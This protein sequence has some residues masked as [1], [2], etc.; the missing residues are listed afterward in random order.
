MNKKTRFVLSLFVLIGALL[1]LAFLTPG[2]IQREAYMGAEYCG[3]CHL[4]E[5]KAWSNSSH[6]KAFV[7]LPAD[8]K[9]ERACLSC[10]AMGTFEKHD[11]IFAG[12]QCESCHGPGLYY[13]VPHSK[14][15]AV[16]SKLLFMNKAESSCI[17][18]HLQNNKIINNHTKFNHA[19]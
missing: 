17:T 18:C 2:P 10:H 8:K 11:P 1:S 19:Q 12:V 13:A 15:D 6:S 4:E 3:S 7:H 14:K 5:Y 16:L 9:E